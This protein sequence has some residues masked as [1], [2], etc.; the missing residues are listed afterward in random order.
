M[1][2]FSSGEKPKQKM[3]WIAGQTCAGKT[4]I[5]D[6]LATRGYHHIDGDQ[7]N[8]TTEPELKAMWGNLFKATIEFKKEG[9]CDENLWKPYYEFLIKKYKEGLE[10]GKPVV[11]T[12]AILNLFGEHEWIAEQLPGV[13]FLKVEV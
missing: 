11:L 8:Q 9:K 13:E 5:G 12:F 1:D 3:L 6:Y 10:T 7:G 2:A 4:F